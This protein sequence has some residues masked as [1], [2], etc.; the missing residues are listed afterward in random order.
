VKLGPLSH[1]ALAHSGML[2]PWIPGQPLPPRKP[3][4]GAFY[5]GVTEGSK[6]GV[7]TGRGT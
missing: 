4:A 1:N 2:Q 7:L 5:C 6:L 3:L